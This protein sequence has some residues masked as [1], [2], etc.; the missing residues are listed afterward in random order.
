[1]RSK[2]KY[3]VLLT[4]YLVLISIISITSI[5]TPKFN[6]LTEENFTARLKK[7]KFSN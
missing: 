1:M 6:K 2:T 4:Y 3:L 7:A 5:A